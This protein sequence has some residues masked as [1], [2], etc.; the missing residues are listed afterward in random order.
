MFGLD[1]GEFL[2]LFIVVLVFVNPKDLPK[3][4]YQ[5]GKIYG[6]LMEAYHAMT[7]QL[8]QLGE[9]ARLEIERAKWEGDKT[10][11]TPLT[12]GKED[13][14]EEIGP[15]GEPVAQTPAKTA[16]PKKRAVKRKKKR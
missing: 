10:P 8:N 12:T 11:P 9:Q 13:P 4:I 3:F 1:F 7:R 16:A 6:Q 2:I 5:V 14:R 15:T